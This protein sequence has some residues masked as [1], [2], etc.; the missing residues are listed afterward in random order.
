MKRATEQFSLEVE[1]GER[2]EHERAWDSGDTREDRIG[3]EEL[4]GLESLCIFERIVRVFFLVWVVGVKY[5]VEYIMDCWRNPI[6]FGTSFVIVTDRS[7][8]GGL[9]EMTGL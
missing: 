9:N 8:G 5:G 7:G 2:E 6:W 3:R 4:Y 1:N